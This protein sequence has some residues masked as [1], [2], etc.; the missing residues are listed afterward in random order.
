LG[1]VIHS[2]RNNANAIQNES[3]LT[4]IAFMVGN[5]TSY[6]QLEQLFALFC[7]L[8]TERFFTLFIT[9]Y[10]N[11]PKDDMVQR[12]AMLADIFLPISRDEDASAV[13]KIRA[14]APDILINMEVCSPSERLAFF[15][16]A[17]VPHKFLWAEAPF[18]PIAPDVRTLAGARL[19]VEDMLPT[20]SLPELGEVFELPELPFTDEAARKIG[21]PPVL[22]CLVP[23]TGIARNGWQLFAETLLQHPDATLAINLEEL[24][25]AAQTFISGQFSSAGVD[26]ARLVFINARTAEEYCLLWQSIDLGLLPPVN[27]GGL[28]LHT[29][30]WMGRPCLVPGSLLPWSQRPTAF[31]KALGKEEWMAIASPHYIDLALQLAQPSQQM[32]PD[33]TLRER[34]KALGLTDSKGFA[35]GFAEAMTGLRRSCQPISRAISD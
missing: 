28:A 9:C 4:R 2:N 18:P 31:L 34:M 26:P 27:P 8:P 23:A 10:T 32:K 30:L 17:P 11:P 5:F 20:L 14:L 19:C 15:L 1:E 12:C 6:H 7:Y 24:G 22:G 25:Q 21:N 16:A 35:Q 13:E 3:G 29:C 33:P